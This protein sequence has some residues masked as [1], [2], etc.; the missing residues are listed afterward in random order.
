MNISWY[1]VNIL[2]YYAGKNEYFTISFSPLK[3]YNRKNFITIQFSYMYLCIK[4]RMYG[5]QRHEGAW[6]GKKCIWLTVSKYFKMDLLAVC[7]VLKTWRVSWTSWILI[8]RSDYN[9]KNHE[10][11]SSRK[12]PAVHNSVVREQTEIL[13]AFCSFPYIYSH[14]TSDHHSHNCCMQE[15]ENQ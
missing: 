12:F 6:K 10:N 11:C 4:Y 5:G 1:Y 2:W 15:V 9:H 3:V 7:H 8:S 14:N 13:W